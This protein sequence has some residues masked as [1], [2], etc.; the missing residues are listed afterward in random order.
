[1]NNTKLKLPK[2]KKTTFA[3]R[4]DVIE[5]MDEELAESEKAI[6]FEFA[7]DLL[8]KS[9]S[10]YKIT[11]NL[12]L[13]DKILKSLNKIQDELKK[14]AFNLVN[15]NVPEY[16]KAVNYSTKAGSIQLNYKKCN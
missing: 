1:M 9:N 11:E 6:K 7:V 2:K 10:I 12:F 4:F 14:Q 5:K 13:D 8:K 3:E 16:T 15:K